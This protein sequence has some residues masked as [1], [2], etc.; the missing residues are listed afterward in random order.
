MKGKPSSMIF[1]AQK[2]QVVASRATDL[3]LGSR[4]R[5]VEF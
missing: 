3:E 4:L 1:E 5:A 2:W